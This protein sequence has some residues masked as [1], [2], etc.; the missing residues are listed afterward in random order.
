MVPHDKR[1]ENPGSSQEGLGDHLLILHNDNF[2]TFDDVIDALIM[3]CQHDN[4]QAEQ[5]ATLTHYI[6]YCEI[7]R[8]SYDELT[9]LQRILE[10]HSLNVTID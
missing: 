9:D 4:V 3:H 1:K 8:G 7:K 6:G 2:N 5:C 10:D